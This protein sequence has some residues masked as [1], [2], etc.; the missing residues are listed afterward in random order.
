MNTFS[1]IYKHIPT[2]LYNYNPISLSVP[3]KLKIDLT[4]YPSISEL[5]IDYTNIE[6]VLDFLHS[7]ESSIQD[8]LYYIY[9]NLYMNTVHSLSIL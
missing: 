8:E 1:N 2:A 3:F 9:N 5:L 6:D 7:I 4:R